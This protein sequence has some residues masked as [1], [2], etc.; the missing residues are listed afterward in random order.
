LQNLYFHLIWQKKIEAEV[1]HRRDTY[2]C[3]LG[4]YYSFQVGHH[5]TFTT[6]NMWITAFNICLQY[7]NRSLSFF[8]SI[9]WLSNMYS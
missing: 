2:I 9:H 4:V 3:L 5:L 6:W 8:H 7:M 1:I